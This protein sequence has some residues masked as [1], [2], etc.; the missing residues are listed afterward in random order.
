[1]KTINVKFKE[2]DYKK[3]VKRP[4][5]ESDFETLIREDCILTDE[6]GKLILLY[7]KFPNDTSELVK[8]CKEIPYETSQRSG[9][10]KTTSRIFGFDPFTGI[11][12]PYCSATSLAI[13][14]PKQHKVIT[15]FGEQINEIY[16]KYLPEAYNKHKVI[17]EEKIEV[18]WRIPKTPFTSGIIN[19][20]N[21]LNYHFDS[22]NFQGVYSNMIVLKNNVA[23]GYLSLPTYGVGLEC[24]NNTLVMFDGQSILHGVTPIKFFGQGAYRYS[25]IYYTLQ[26][27]WNC[28]DLTTELA[29][30]R[31]RRIKIEKRNAK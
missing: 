5:K 20:N 29:K 8:A 1:M 22:G 17:A 10:L 6:N 21:Q 19:K 28:D 31:N 7:F 23:G 3:Y 30:V 13:K 11:R 18:G 9:G 26:S 4:A 25:L 16:Q 24:A 14:F 2:V 12:K 27:M 15:K